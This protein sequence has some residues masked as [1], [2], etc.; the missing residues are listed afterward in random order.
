MSTKNY[1]KHTVTDTPPTF[2]DVGDE[3][4]DPKTNRLYK[5][6][7]YN[8]TNVAYSQIIST[9][10]DGNVPITG[11][12]TLSSSS[13]GITFGD[14]T[15]QTTV[16]SGGTIPG[17]LTVGAVSSNVSINTA[18]GSLIVVGGLGVSGNIYSGNIL[19]STTSSGVTFGDGTR[20]TSAKP[21][22]YANNTNSGTYV[23]DTNSYDMVVITN[24]SSTI[25]SITTTGTPANGQKL[26]ISITGT[27]TCGFTLSSSNFE[28]STVALPTTTAGTARL[29]V[30]FIWNV[31]NTKWRCVATA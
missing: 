16:F 19:F 28:A 31:A 10:I 8:G 20:Q 14:G 3:Y 21:R 29:D 13:G 18:T 22:V 26:I 7:I 11:N 9:G 2:S 17:Q 1:L 6:V 5:K 15:V 25:S 23:I 24:Q 12:I 30:G 27:T 4:F